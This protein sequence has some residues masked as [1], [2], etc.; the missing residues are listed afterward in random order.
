MTGLLESGPAFCKTPLPPI[1]GNHSCPVLALAAICWQWRQCLM[2]PNNAL[3]KVRIHFAVDVGHADNIPWRSLMSV[4]QFNVRL[5]TVVLA[6]FTVLSGWHCDDELCQALA[7]AEASI[8]VD[9]TAAQCQQWCETRAPRVADDA[10]CPLAW[11]VGQEWPEEEPSAG[12]VDACVDAVGASNADVAVLEACIA[13]DPLCYI[14]LEMC[15]DMQDANAN[16]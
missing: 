10:W 15:V 1:C 4:P 6:C 2:Q 16:A 14:S 3:S 7:D 9:D 5:L 12:C 13:D 8:D 11:G